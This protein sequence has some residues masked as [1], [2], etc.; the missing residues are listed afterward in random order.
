MNCGQPVYR[1]QLWDVGHIID[2]ERGGRPVAGNVGP[3]H[4]GCNRR[5]G[6]KRGGTI[7]SRARRAAANR[8]QNLRD[9]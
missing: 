7:R 4:R 2:A 3:A 1:E 9:W 8:D 5:A 6:G